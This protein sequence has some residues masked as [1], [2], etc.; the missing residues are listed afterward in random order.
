MFIELKNWKLA[1]ILNL[2]NNVM[3]LFIFVLILY[4]KK[5]GNVSSVFISSSLLIW[6]HFGL[7]FEVGTFSYRLIIVLYLFKCYVLFITDVGISNL[8]PF[9]WSWN[10]KVAFLN[11]ICFIRECGKG[12]FHRSFSDLAVVMGRPKYLVSNN[13]KFP[14]WEIF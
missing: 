10:K 11:L 3:N 1:V 12:F 8:A 7:L 2:R 6:C 4:L 9:I 5:L 13:F 14:S